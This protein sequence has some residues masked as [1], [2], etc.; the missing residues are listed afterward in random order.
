MFC[1]SGKGS[2]LSLDVFPPVDTSD[3]DYVIGLIDLSTYNSIPNIENDVNNK[4]YYDSK[5][6]V[7]LAEGSYE[8]E[9]IE[10]YILKKLPKG[11]EF[12]LKANNNT[13][14]AEISCN[15]SI[16][17][18]KEHTIGP[19]LGF[20]SKSLNPGETH[21]S[22]LP[23]NI[24]RVN[25]IRVECNVVRGSYVNGT[26]GHVIHEFYPSVEPGFKILEQPG[27]IIYLP[28]NVQKVQNITVQLKDQDG[29]PINLRDETLSLRLHLKR[30]TT[31]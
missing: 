27:T 11:V 4:F 5:E 15:K 30:V 22:D 18:D 16:N 31:I 6:V 17:F 1:L 19:M 9:D 28:I 26:E 3:G 13:L 29:N 12:S 21:I 25:S 7:N 23:V 10:K 14:K 20:G 8:I 2:T 24:L